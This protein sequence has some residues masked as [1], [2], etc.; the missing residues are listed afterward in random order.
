MSDTLAEL[1][2]RLAQISDLRTARGVLEWDQQVVMPP[3]GAQARADHLTTL[4]TLQHDL[5]ISEEIGRLLDE[6]RPLEDSLPYED[7]DACLLRVTRRDWEKATRVPTELAAEITH[8]TA[9]AHHAWVAARAAS[10]YAAFRPWLDR[11]LELKQRYLECFPPGDDPYDVFLDD[12]EPG[13]KTAEV[14][15]IFDRIKP[16]LVELVATGRDYEPEPFTNGPFGREAQ[17]EVS[18]EVM[19][20]FGCR[21]ELVPPR[22]QRASVLH[23]LFGHRRATRRPGMPRTI[24][25]GTPSSRPCMR[26]ATAC[27]SGASTRVSA[28]ARSR[29]AAH[30]RC[31]SR[32]A[33][34][35]R[36]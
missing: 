18:L 7:V 22:S 15:A 13:M 31:T 29:M 12:F 26:R 27:T 3:G 32:K 34:S 28:A 1:K 2:T 24:S 8:V 6:L 17:H 23:E 36:T 10:D 4:E 5:F 21:R 30:R 9:E 25:P 20:A 11:I 14:R 33:A 16:V 19:R 35:G